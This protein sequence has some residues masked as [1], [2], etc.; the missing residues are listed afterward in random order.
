MTECNSGAGGH[1]VISHRFCANLKGS[2]GGKCGW[3]GG[4][5]RQTCRWCRGAGRWLTSGNCLLA[6]TRRGGGRTGPRSVYRIIGSAIKTASLSSC[7]SICR[8]STPAA[9]AAAGWCGVSCSSLCV[10]TPELPRPRLSV[11][12]LPARPASRLP[13]PIHA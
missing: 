3:E 5:N 12:V 13:L 8:R 6:L 11:W 1:P 4:L 7:L 10:V 2:S 9:A